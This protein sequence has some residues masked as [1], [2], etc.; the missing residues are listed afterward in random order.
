MILG[1][2]NFDIL[3]FILLVFTKIIQSYQ[4]TARFLFRAN[5]VG[6]FAAKVWQEI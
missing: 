4:N 3:W 6:Y 5:N 2:E 1:G